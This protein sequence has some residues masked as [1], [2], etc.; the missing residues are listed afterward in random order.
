LTAQQE[1]TVAIGDRERIAIGAIGSF[2][3]TL[4]ISA[5]DV[6]GSQDLGGGPARMTDDAAAPFG[7]GPSRDDSESRR[8]FLDVAKTSADVSFSGS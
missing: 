8:R 5:P 7:G 1:A 4:E 3:L 6:V 2:E